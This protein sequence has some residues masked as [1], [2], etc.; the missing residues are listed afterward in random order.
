MARKRTDWLNLGSGKSYFHR[1]HRPL[2]CL[3]FITPLLL[4]YQIASVVHPWALHSAGYSP[5]VVAFVLM[6]NFFGWF[7]A[8]GNVLP[9]LAVV[10][11]LMFWHLA[12][13]DPW[14]FEPKLYAGMAVE[15]VVW[16]V[17][18][19]VIGLAVTRHMPAMAWM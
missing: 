2:Q 10:A 4:F 18:F 15:S 7:G 11:I 12:K 3:I 1:V 16:G 17:P 19:V 5:H 9:L 14:D 8:A 6:L 13:K